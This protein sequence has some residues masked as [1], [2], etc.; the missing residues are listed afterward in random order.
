MNLVYQACL[1]PVLVA[2]HEAHRR[3]G[4][5][6]ATLAVAVA[7]IGMAVYAANNAAIPMAVLAGRYGAA[8]SEAQR[9]L[10]A[11]AGEAVLARGEDFTPGAF[12]GTLF[13]LLGTLGISVVMLRGRLFGRPA[14]WTGL[15][16]STLLLL[17]TLVATFVPS[18]F[19][20]AFFGLGM[21]GGLCTLAWFLLTGLGLF[22]L[23]RGEAGRR[24]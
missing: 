9:A 3:A 14:G 19:L 21:T 20:P 5:N 4:G 15:A 8:G 12:P 1:V 10:L 16:G 17:F 2:L 11:A 18:L 13:Q 23:A 22:R 7:F 6:L 24:G